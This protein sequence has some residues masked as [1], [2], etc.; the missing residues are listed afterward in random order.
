MYSIILTKP[1]CDSIL[2][3]FLE[4]ILL[5]FL[6]FFNLCSG[7]YSIQKKIL[8]VQALLIKLFLILICFSE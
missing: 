4:F 3:L 8:C 1:K 6:L 7:S 5:C 2:F